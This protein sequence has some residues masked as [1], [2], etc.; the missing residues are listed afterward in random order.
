MAHIEG[1]RI[2]NYKALKDITLGKLWNNHESPL[3]DLT[4]VIG[5]N[6]VG[7]SSI[8]DAF[9]FIS[10]C[11][12]NGIE[13][14]CDVRGGFSKII[15]KGCTSDE[16]ISFELYYKENNNEQP[17]TYEFSIT[18]DSKMRPY[19]VS[20]RLRQRR[21]GQKNYGRPFSF[22]ILNNG[23]GIVWKGNTEGKQI[24]EEN[25]SD[26]FDIKSLISEIESG[27]NAEETNETE[28][29]RLEDNRHLA[30]T[31]L[32]ALKQ[33][34]R[35]VS[36]RKFIE[37]WYLSYFS[38]NSARSLPLAGV[39]KHINIRGE[40]LANVVQFMEREQPSHLKNVLNKIS[41]KIPGLQRIE[42]ETSSDGRLLLKFYA[43][44]FGDAPFYAQQMSD[45][46]LKIFTYLLLLEDPEPHSFICIEEPENGLYHKLLALL[47]SEFRRFASEKKK[48]SQIFI[49]TH[50]PYFL[51][52]LEP[53]EVWILEK[54][55][56]GFSKISRASSNELVN[57]LVKEG[58]DLGDL[59]YS[60]YLD[61]E[62]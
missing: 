40:N 46:T 49:T 13:E 39:Q 23:E 50:Q 30:I 55:K 45:G 51:N 58:I 11:L 28:V 61:G 34:P 31:T 17:I 36:F 42:T 62:E 41:E 21:K 10:D 12:K 6:G 16:Y 2:K 8:F 3:S 29:V 9:G 38:P 26:K 53:E 43:Q 35:I 54:Q 60:D 20:E 32:G 33:H 59:W 4:V 22:L 47:A 14:A 7:K 57:N 48:N 56:D 24:K 44:G 27:N 19:V 5:K 37:S 1:I 15:S 52:A 18:L 25:N